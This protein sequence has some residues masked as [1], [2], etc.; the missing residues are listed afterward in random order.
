MKRLSLPSINIRVI[1][2]PKIFAGRE[3]AITN[4][5]DSDTIAVSGLTSLSVLADST[6]KEVIVKKLSYVQHITNRVDTV[7]SDLDAWLD[8]GEGA[9]IIYYTDSGGVI[10]N[11]HIMADVK[12]IGLSTTGPSIAVRLHGT[13]LVGSSV[14]DY[15]SSY[16]RGEA[17]THPHQ[18]I[19]DYLP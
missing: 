10:T 12:P 14:D 19:E 13:C 9:M 11:A 17:V 16:L 7:I 8:D 3:M 1:S 15:V 2:L 6:K 18:Y 5:I 4:Y